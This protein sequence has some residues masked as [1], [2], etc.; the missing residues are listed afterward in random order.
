MGEA[1]GWNDGPTETEPAEI[2]SIRDTAHPVC[3]AGIILFGGSI[4]V[5]NASAVTLC[6]VNS[7]HDCKVGMLTS[8]IALC[9]KTYGIHDKVR[10]HYV[11]QLLS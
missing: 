4:M 9:L 1:K 5:R 7:Q 10:L 6:D 3:I 8:P 11:V 2:V